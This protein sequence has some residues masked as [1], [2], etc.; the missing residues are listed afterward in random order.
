[1]LQLLEAVIPNIHFFKNHSLELD[2]I[3]NKNA[4]FQVTLQ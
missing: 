3:E 4:Y 2:L 1:M